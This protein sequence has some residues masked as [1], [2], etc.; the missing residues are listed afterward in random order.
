MSLTHD[1]AE[2]IKTV[3]DAGMGFLGVTV[4]LGWVNLAVGFCVIIW[5]LVR[6]YEHIV[7][8][9]REKREMEFYLEE[10]KE[11][12]IYSDEYFSLLPVTELRDIYRNNINSKSEDPS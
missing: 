1:T 5:Y 11:H 7:R 6:L 2:Q 3:T 12:H 10:L 8:K 4:I 9:A